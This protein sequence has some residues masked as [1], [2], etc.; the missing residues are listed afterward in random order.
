FLREGRDYAI[1]CLPDSIGVTECPDTVPKLVAQRERWQR[2]I[3]ETVVHY[4]RMW[5]NPGYGSVGL[6]GSPFYL[7]TE[8]ISPAVEILALG[9]L[10]AAIGFGLFDAWTFLAVVGA[11]AFTSAALTA[12]AV[13][14]DDV[15]SRLYRR[16]DL[17]RLLLYAPL[18]LVLYR[19]IIFWARLKGS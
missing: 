19:P 5:F 11:M 9:A 15:Q 1:H 7:L 3:N 10:V 4:R 12:A 13:F 17:I 16:R 18:E 14:L 8:V 2:V 6:V